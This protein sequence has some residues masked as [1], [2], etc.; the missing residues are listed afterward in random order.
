MHGNLHV[1]VRKCHFLNGTLMCFLKSQALQ[2]STMSSSTLT[3][4]AVCW[5]KMLHVPFWCVLLLQTAHSSATAAK[6]KKKKQISQNVGYCVHKYFSAL[7]QAYQVCD[8]PNARKLHI[9]NFKLGFFD[10]T[11]IFQTMYP[12]LACKM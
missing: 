10:L 4:I 7:H 6:K 12:H 1:G 11:N 9:Q 8:H 5:Q 3:I 2:Y